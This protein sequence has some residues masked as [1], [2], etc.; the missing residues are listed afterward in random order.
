M[1]TDIS[2]DL[3]PGI[4]E[5]CTFIFAAGE[6]SHAAFKLV[7]GYA[8]KINRLAEKSFDDLANEIGTNR[9]NPAKAMQIL[10]GSGSLNRI[11]DAGLGY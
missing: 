10:K 2:S 11:M 4:K 7:D 8:E 9:T 3:P 1:L 5:Y 6:A